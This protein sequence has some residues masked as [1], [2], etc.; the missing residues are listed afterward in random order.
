M[1]FGACSSN[2]MKMKGMLKEDNAYEHN[3][4][5]AKGTLKTRDHSFKNNLRVLVVDDDKAT[6][7]LRGMGV[8]VM[9]VG[10]SAHLTKKEQHEFL[11]AGANEFHMKPITRAKLVAPLQAVDEE[12]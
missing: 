9:L 12:L 6:M 5:Q 2:Y 10:V 4:L 3:A 1:A 11:V 8:G 7:F